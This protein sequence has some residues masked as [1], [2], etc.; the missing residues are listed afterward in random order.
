TRYTDNEARR[1][2]NLI[3]V[4]YDHNVNILI[5]ADCT[6]DELY[7][8]TRLVFE[9]QRTISRLTEMQSHDYLAQPHIV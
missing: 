8:G 1:F 9:F 2:I 6:V 4:L 7:I 5:A 3:D